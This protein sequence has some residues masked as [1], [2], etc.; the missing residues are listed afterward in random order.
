MLSKTGL[1]RNRFFAVPRFG[2]SMS[3]V[4]TDIVHR[5]R[6]AAHDQPGPGR[7]VTPARC[8][9]LDWE[10]GT[11]ARCVSTKSVKRGCIGSMLPYSIP[12]TSYGLFAGFFRAESIV[13]FTSNSSITDT[14]FSGVARY[15][16]ISTEVAWL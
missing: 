16:I 6:S 3:L 2:T 4:A 10:R 11:G 13:W 1:S 7:P 9:F 12:I 5:A 14:Y 15:S 8:R